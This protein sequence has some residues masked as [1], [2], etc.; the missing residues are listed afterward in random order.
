[1]H[2]GQQRV[3]SA[4]VGGSVV[5]VVTV[6]VLARATFPGSDVRVGRSETRGSV[7]SGSGVGRGGN[8]AGGVLNGAVP[9]DERH[10][11][12]HVLV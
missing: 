6:T 12:V 5:F 1:M 8:G 3:R 11:R 7:K 2:L 4:V 10:Y 9:A